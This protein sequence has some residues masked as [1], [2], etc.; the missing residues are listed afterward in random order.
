MSLSVISALQAEI[1]LT[2]AEVFF[3]KPG[4][5]IPEWFSLP[6][7][8]WPLFSSLETLNRLQPS[9]ELASAMEMMVKVAGNSIEDRLREYKALFIGARHPQIWLYASHYLD[10]RVPGP[11][12]FDV[13]RLYALAGLEVSGA[14]LP[15]HV[16]IELAFLA[17]LA[18]WEQHDQENAEDWRLSK[19]LFLKKHFECWF[20]EVIRGLTRSSYQAWVAIGHVAGAVLNSHQNT[21]KKRNP[22]RSIPVITNEDE[23]ILC[24]FCVQECPLRALTIHET[25]LATALWLEP[26]SCNGCRKCVAVCPE[27]VLSLVGSLNGKSRVLLRESPRVKCP[28]C[29]NPAMS[30]AE[31]AHVSSKIGDA[32]W[33][34]YCTDC[35]IA[36]PHLVSGRG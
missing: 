31:I 18:E 20:P 26:G 21:P 29:G 5:K 28:G 3:Y 7:E 6:G 13:K 23:C 32:P 16:S 4:E 25:G 1:Y 12:T 33:L 27:G 30:E 10:G 34:V 36:N 2:L 9:P 35:R 24:G 19:H 22:K 11:S 8:R 14:E 15:D 17:H